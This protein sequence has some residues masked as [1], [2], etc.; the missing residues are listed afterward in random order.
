M[1]RP[2]RAQRVQATLKE[3]NHEGVTSHARTG[4]VT[5]RSR[6]VLPGRGSECLAGSEPNQRLRRQSFAKS[7]QPGA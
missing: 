6:E 2:A 5:E 4:K 1:R 3:T 7:F